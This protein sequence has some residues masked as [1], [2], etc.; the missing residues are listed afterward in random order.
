MPAQFNYGQNCPDEVNTDP[1]NPYNPDRPDLE[2]TFF[3]FP[4]N[5]NNHNNFEIITGGGTY[6]SINNPF[7]VPT[8]LMVGQLV[9]LQNSDFY[10]EDGWE[11]LKVNFGRLND[12]TERANTT[13]MPYMILYN[14]YS[15]TMRFLGMWPDASNSWQIIRFQISLPQ[16]KWTSDESGLNLDA[17]N[18]LSVQGDAIQ[19]LDQQTE[20]TV[21]EVI[22]E[23]PGVS[24]ASFF[25]W[26]DLPVAYDPCI[27]NNDVALELEATL[28][29]KWDVTVKGV[30]DAQVIQQGVPQSGYSSLVAKRIIGAAGATAG[31]IATGG[32]VIN[33]GGFTG[34]LD[35]FSQRPGVSD[36]TKAGLDLLQG[37]LNAAAE[38]TYDSQKLEWRNTVTGETLT[39]KDWEKL[40]SG[41]GSFLNAGVDFANPGSST[42]KPTTS[43]VGRITATGTATLNQNSGNRVYLGVPGSNWA[44]SLDEIIQSTSNGLNPEAPIYNNPLGTF[45]MLKTPTFKVKSKN[46]SFCHPCIVGNP[47]AGVTPNIGAHQRTQLSLVLNDPLLYYINP[48]LD[49]NNDNSKILVSLVVADRA[50]NVDMEATN[51]SGIWSGGWVSIIGEHKELFDGTNLLA[52][53]EED[54]YVSTPVPIDYFA[55][56]ITQFMADREVD[57]ANDFEFFIRFNL[58]LTSNKVGRN[59]EPN[60]IRQVLTFPAEVVETEE[61]FEFPLID[62]VNSESQ[63][64]YNETK[65][66]ASG[67]IGFADEYV[68]ISSHVL[69]D[70]QEL[71]SILSSSV[72]HLKPGTQVSRKMRLA[73]DYPFQGL[74]PQEEVSSAYVSDFCQNNI[75]DNQYQA[76]HFSAFA[77]QLQPPS[78]EFLEQYIP[79]DNTLKRID[80]FPNPARSELTLRATGGG[81]SHITIYDTSGRPVM[82]A[83]AGGGASEHRMDIGAIA[84]GIYIVQATCGDEVHA[85]KLV[86]AR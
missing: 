53:I 8:S 41:I 4:H 12:G 84:P 35:I 86:V 44:N 13:S 77:P 49:V 36:E 9:N 85:E 6:P 63:S 39:K 43:V 23:Y 59:G 81:L 18:L 29:N 38:V 67:E 11:L 19:P 50:A 20:E 33:T 68:E 70:N 83:N 24:N 71:A 31:A 3:W 82:Q 32:A 61:E 14:R 16:K 37:S 40:F 80:L 69:S 22:T 65:L 57:D 15:G 21:Y 58:D 25:F 26:F 2:N 27:C 56:L 76:N 54:K 52:T 72:I 73:I 64:N 60:K 55:E 34:L 47:Q 46:Y 28:E 5:E 1:R 48:A 42:G 79:S 51:V 74:N 62:L 10:P 17:T 75:I 66:F 30:L 7:W 45:A 78:A